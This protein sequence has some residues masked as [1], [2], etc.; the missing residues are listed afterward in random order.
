MAQR[1]HEQIATGLSKI[2][3]VLRHQAWAA[4]A[5]RGLSPTQ[6]QALVILSGNRPDG[7]TVSALAREL[8]I[9]VASVSD[10][11]SSLEKKGLV[12]KQ[13]DPADARTLRLRLTRS[14]RSAARA[15][16]QWP[17]L[18]LAAI[19]A[20]DERERPVFVRG[21]VKMIRS[22]QETGAIPVSRMCPSCTFFRPNAYPGADAPHHCAYVNAP[23][24]D[25]ALRI[26]CADHEETAENEQGPL[27]TRF[28]EG[29]GLRRDVTR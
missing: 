28:V 29:R 16:A 10:S 2:S 11:V 13:P 15:A 9:S 21:L 6:A 8:A 22:L 5:Q 27:W 17:D 26:D 12:T 25:A 24:G 23:F 14:G 7:D 20:L 3:L 1:N 19:D 18:L 4:S